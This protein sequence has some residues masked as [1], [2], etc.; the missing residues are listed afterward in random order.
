[1]AD[2]S[3][4]DVRADYATDYF[5]EDEAVLMLRQWLTAL[6]LAADNPDVPVRE[7]FDGLVAIA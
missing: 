1:M 5:T 3:G 7:L 4:W 6:S 2:G